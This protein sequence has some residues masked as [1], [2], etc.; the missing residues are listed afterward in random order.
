M[1]SAGGE[2]TFEPE[3]DTEAGET[4][5]DVLRD[6]DDENQRIVLTDQLNEAAGIG[7]SSGRRQVDGYN[8]NSTS[9]NWE[10][11]IRSWMV[12]RTSGGWH[13]PNNVPLYQ[14]TGMISAGRENRG[15]GSWVMVVD[16]SGSMRDSVLQEIMQR[17]QS[18]IDTINPAKTIILPV[19]HRVHEPV[20]VSRGG[21]VPLSLEGGGGTRF[22]V[23]FD[24]IED[25]Y[26]E[27]E[28]I[29]F[30]TDGDAVDFTTMREPVT[31]LLWLTYG[32]PEERYPFGEAIK[33]SLYD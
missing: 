6:I 22:Q 31:P 29:V 18:A 11:L 3:V 9:D 7:G 2:D 16:T 17:I 21:K 12:S 33:V 10:E 25:N 27:A 28:G 23:A 15:I 20:E 24:F 8:R 13:K 1:G 32:F 26:P 14:S 4:P 19:D 30:L 5:E